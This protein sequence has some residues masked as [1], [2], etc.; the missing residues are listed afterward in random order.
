M[1]ALLISTLLTSA[2][3][4]LNPFAITQQFVLQSMVKKPKLVKGYGQVLF[5]AELILVIA[6]LI[7]VGEVLQS[8]EIEL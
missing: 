2:A 1:W 7:G 5:T 6:F 3:D 4:S 8:N